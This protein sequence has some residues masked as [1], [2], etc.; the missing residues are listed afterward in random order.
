MIKDMDALAQ[1]LDT[2]RSV[3]ESYLSPDILPTSEDLLHVARLVTIGEMAACFAHE[4]MNPLTMIR[5]NLSIA[6]YELPDDHPAHLYLEAIGRA[7][8]RI[9]ELARRMLN[10]SKKRNAV[11]QAYDV[12]EIVADAM[13]FMQPYFHEQETHIKTRIPSGLP[14]IEVDR[15]Q[16]VQALVNLLQNGRKPWCH[17]KTGRSPLPWLRNITISG[18]ASEIPAAA[19]RTR[20]C[21]ESLLRSLPPKGRPEPGS[22]FTSREGS[23]KST[24]AGS[25]SKPVPAGPCSR[26]HY[27]YRIS[28]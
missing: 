6:N 27:R 25:A 26:F 9:E 14:H 17:R 18:S 7:E 16:I 21:P 4:V 22:D 12:A 28:P 2:R 19:L 1:K 20:I 5:G 11:S 13:R 24:A 15:W 8:R 23:W 3:A 10:F